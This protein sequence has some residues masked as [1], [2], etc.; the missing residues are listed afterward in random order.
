MWQQTISVKE[1]RTNFPKVKK[2]LERGVNYTL[3][4]RSKPIAQIRPLGSSPDAL[5]ALLNAPSSLHFSSKK[6][7]VELVRK[8]RD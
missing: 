4:Y 8:V 5:Q 1:L 2:A 6:T 7:A 3:I